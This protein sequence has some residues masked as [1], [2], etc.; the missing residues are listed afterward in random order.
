M[1]ILRKFPTA[2]EFGGNL[3]PKLGNNLI[4]QNQ[5]KY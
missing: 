4:A 5:D 2:L 3:R 1:K